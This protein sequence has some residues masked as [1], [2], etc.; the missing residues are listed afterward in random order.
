MIAATSILANT[1]LSYITLAHLSLGMTGAAFSRVAASLVNFGLGIYFLR[2]ILKV[3]FDKEALWK[4]AT[5][6]VIMAITI[7][8]SRFFGG[9]I[10]ELYFLHIYVILGSVVYFFSLV[11]LKA[12]K[13]QDMELVHDYLPGGLK[14]VA[15]W[16]SR[17]AS[18]E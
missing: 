10:Y 2:G 11:G 15:V 16:L 8:T 17:L 1:T 4:A 12:I 7:L 3:T 18:V 6:T 14:R 13:K 9:L 5:A